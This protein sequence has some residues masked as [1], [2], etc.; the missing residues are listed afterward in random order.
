MNLTLSKSLTGSV[1]PWIDQALEG[2]PEARWEF[3]MLPMQVSETEH[4]PVLV[5]MLW[6]PGPILGTCLG[7]SCPIQNPLTLTRESIQEVIPGMVSHLAD[8]RS[9]Q[10]EH[11]QKQQQSPNLRL[12]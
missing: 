10:L 11:L 8:Q 4:Q 9:Q 2:S 5:L 12:T 7:A 6:M 3:S 1:G